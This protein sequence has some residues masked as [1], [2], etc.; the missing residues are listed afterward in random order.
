[1]VK[2]QVRGSGEN[3]LQVGGNYWNQGK[4]VRSSSERF[5]IQMLRAW[6]RVGTGVGGLGD[7]RW[8]CRKD[9]LGMGSMFAVGGMEEGR[10]SVKLE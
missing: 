8:E 3:E 2:D 4:W 9:C 6:I 1:M 7:A 10:E 5:R